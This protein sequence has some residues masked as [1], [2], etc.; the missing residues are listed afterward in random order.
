[1]DRRGFIK[2]SVALAVAAEQG[3]A[4]TKEA[5]NKDTAR[6]PN[7]ARMVV[8]LSMQFE[9]GSQAPRGVNGPRGE[10]DTKYP[11]LPT[12]KWYEYGIKEGIPR[13]L[14]CTIASV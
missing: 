7:G 14:E 4:Q 9:S 8:S 2:N 6:W 10:Q 1:M 13:L 12:E 5:Q 3:E 11:D